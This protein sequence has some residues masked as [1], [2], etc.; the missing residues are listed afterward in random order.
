MLSRGL[1]NCNPGNIRLSVSKFQGEVVPSTDP[2][3]KQFEQMAWGYRAMFVIIH[4]YNELYSINTL[5]K[6]IARWAPQ[7][8]NDT[9]SYIRSVA[10]RLGCTTNAHINTLDRDV[11]CRLV[12][13]MSWI[14]N[15][16]KADS[17]EVEAGW[18]LFETH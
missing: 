7:H 12:A 17:K 15:G 10:K 5:N 16:T 13:S 1:R 14:E 8:E 9:N 18:M 2:D 6:I 3:F 4:N 11:M